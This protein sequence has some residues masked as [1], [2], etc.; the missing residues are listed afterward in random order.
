[1]E[2][3]NN[4]GLTIIIV[5][6]IVLLLG[7]VCYI[8]YDKFLNNDNNNNVNSPNN[9]NKTKEDT[10]FYSI[11][12]LLKNHYI[13][14]LTSTTSDGI[15][16]KDGSVYYVATIGGKLIKDTSITEQP[17]AVYSTLKGGLVGPLSLYVLTKENNLYYCIQNYSDSETVPTFTKINTKKIANV[18]TEYL[19]GDNFI[20]VDYGDGNLY[21]HSPEGFTNTYK[22]TYKYPDYQDAYKTADTILW[23]IDTDKKLYAF[24]VSETNPDNGEY[25]EVT[26]NQKPVVVKNTFNG[27]LNNTIVNFVID[28]DNNLLTDSKDKT[29]L[30]L[31]KNSKV[32]DAKY[33][34]DK[35]GNYNVTVTLED[36]S[37]ILISNATLSSL[38][39]RNNS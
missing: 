27:Y 37:N 5:T 39:L 20:G 32:K 2:K 29:I 4:K 33:E 35:D 9:T 7:V 10:D 26:Y 36:G 14:K 16:I 13:K 34:K 12:N 38:Y 19:K 21:I 22:E 1:M 24:V 17:V 11:N 3:K 6:L 23:R 30:S 28:N 31:Y 8:C 18:Y 25:K 15:E